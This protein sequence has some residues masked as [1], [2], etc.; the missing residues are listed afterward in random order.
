LTA[1]DETVV[2]CGHGQ[3]T[4]IGRERVANPFLQELAAVPPS[5]GL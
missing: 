4:T 2:Y 1:P 5:R 3:S